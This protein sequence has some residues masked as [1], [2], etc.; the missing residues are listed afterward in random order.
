MLYEETTVTG[1]APARSTTAVLAALAVGALAAAGLGGSFATTAP[2]VVDAA[3]TVS[4]PTATASTATASSALPTTPAAAAP[5]AAS[6]PAAAVVPVVAPVAAPAPAV[7]PVPVTYVVQPGDT[8]SA[9]AAWFEAH[10]YGALYRANAAVIGANPDLIRPG[11]VLVVSAAGVS[12][13][14]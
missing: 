4:A 6:A 8:L 3:A 10:G 12:T 5:V 9:I 13:N 14:G 7:A 11:Q 1:S 2:Q